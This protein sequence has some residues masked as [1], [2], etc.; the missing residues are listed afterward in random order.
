MIKKINLQEA[1]Q[2]TG[3]DKMSLFDKGQRRENLKACSPTKL[4]TYYHICLN[5]GFKNA[6][7]QIKAEMLRRGGLDLYIWP[8]VDKI[9]STQFTPYE[10]QLLLKHKT[11]LDVASVV[12]DLY[13]HP[14]PKLTAAET[15][16]VYLIWAIVLDLPQFVQQIK[17]YFNKQIYYSKIPQML[18]DIIN[19]PGTADIISDI[20]KKL[21]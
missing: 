11:D 1:S 2:L 9:D 12:T 17:L 4:I 20:T 13:I 14:F 6:E 16:L 19:R 15:L 7:Q 5:N 10:A 3:Y 8:E 21:P 18:N